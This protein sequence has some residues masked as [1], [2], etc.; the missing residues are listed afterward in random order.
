MQALS[1]S[2]LEKVDPSAES[3][4]YCRSHKKCKIVQ[5]PVIPYH[6]RNIYLKLIYI[7]IIKYTSCSHRNH[8]V[9]LG[10]GS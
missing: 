10:W 7:H 4:S 2:N 6:L 1:L 5:W 3:N 9:R 8:V